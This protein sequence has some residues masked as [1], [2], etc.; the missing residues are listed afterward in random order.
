MF[1]SSG[2][3]IF[4]WMM[5]A[6]YLDSNFKNVLSILFHL[7]H[8]CSYFWIA[9]SAFFFV[10]IS[11]SLNVIAHISIYILV[12]LDGNNLL[13]LIE[14]AAPVSIDENKTVAVKGCFNNAIMS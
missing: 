1:Y 13:M 10:L 3:S 14:I 5:C 7:S 12:I 6:S 11:H 8:V 9:I 2:G 4:I